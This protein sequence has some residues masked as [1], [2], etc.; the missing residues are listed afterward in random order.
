MKKEET[1]MTPQSHTHHSCCSIVTI[2]L[3]VIACTIANIVGMWYIH[4]M[5]PASV[6]GGK[7][8]ADDLRAIEYEKAGGKE[9]YDL[10]AEYARANSGKQKTE[11][12][13]AIAQLKGQPGA[14][15]APTGTTPVSASTLTSDQY[16]MIF[17]DSYIEGSKDAKI[18]VVEYSDLECPYCIMQF[19]KGIMSQLKT[20][21]GKDINFIFKPLNLARHPGADQK[22]MASLCAAKLG[23]ADAYGKFY[24]AILTRSEVQGS[25]FP[26][27]NLKSLAKEQKL[28]EKKFSECYDA[29]ATQS[30]YSGY[31]A[32]SSQFAVTGTPTTLILNNSTKKYDMVKGAADI[33]N[34]TAVVDTLS[35]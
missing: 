33:A 25:M 24:Q 34:F 18:T 14:P 31:T 15:T 8:I 6:S 19:K 17:K 5:N 27:D 23:G 12:T 2:S 3:V 7:S 16:T 22:G 30:I 1:T 13:A 26:V 29:R 35:K 20:Q 4:T 32:E 9:M 21:Y 28:D 10:Y 11:I